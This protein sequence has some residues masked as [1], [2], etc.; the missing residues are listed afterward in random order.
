GFGRR[1][2]AAAID[3]KVARNEI[4]R[5]RAAKDD[6]ATEGKNA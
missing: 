3:R 1:E 4:K 2:V 5:I 6:I